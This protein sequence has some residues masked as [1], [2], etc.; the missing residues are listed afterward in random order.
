VA[1]RDPGG[2]MFC[3][4]VQPEAFTRAYQV[5]YS[6]EGQPMASDESGSRRFTFSVYFRP[7]EL[8]VA[9][10]V[11][12]EREANRSDA[13]GS[14]SVTTSRELETRLTVDKNRSVLC[15]GAYADGHWMHRNPSCE[16]NIEFKAVAVPADYITVKVD[17]A[18]ARVVASAALAN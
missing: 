12:L 6:Y 15:E 4:S 9:E 16:D 8:S 1:S 11:L 18:Q 2:S 14:F 17:I 7:E 3:P 13:E 10:R 5:T